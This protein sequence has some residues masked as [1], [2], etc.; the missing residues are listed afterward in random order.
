MKYVK[1]LIA[2]MVAASIIAAAGTT[3]FAEQTDP[4]VILDTREAD[5]GFEDRTFTAVF[6][7][8]LLTDRHVSYMFGGSDGMFRP[9]SELSRAEAAQLI[10]NLLS[11]TE[12]AG[13]DF[14][15]VSRDSWYYKAVSTLSGLGII[16][17][18]ED[19]FLP[20]KAATRAEFVAILSRFFPPSPGTASFTDL[21]AAH[22]A[23]EDIGFAVSKGWVSG[24]SDGS[25]KPDNPITRAEAAC[26]VN[27]ALNRAADKSLLN[28]S[29]LLVFIDVSKGYWAYYDIMEAA[30][31][32]K[33][34][35][36]GNVESWTS[37]NTQNLSL[38]A[39]PLY[40]NG[41]LYYIDEH[42][43][44][45]IK[46][47]TLRGFTFDSL[48][49]YTSGNSELD[50]YVKGVL[51]QVTNDSMSQLEKL[52]AAYDF[53]RDSFTYLRRDN[54]EFGH[55]DWEMKNALIM[56]QTG[57]G[58]CYC[59]TAVFYYLARQ[60]GYECTAVSGLIIGSGGMSPHSWVH[61]DFGGETFIFDPELEMAQRAKGKYDYD[62]FMMSYSRVP[63]RYIAPQ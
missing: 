56:I 39:G 49:Q 60:L 19:C 11:G 2:G 9:N 61:I 16:N 25:F 41:N 12:A 32:H 45:P 58:N 52:R 40:F 15:D 43:H 33:Y 13:R 23:Y 1:R 42:T 34:T 18:Y 30:V 44:Q 26:I 55:T 54:Y 4:A 38:P 24:Y 59:Y 21:S 7:P 63:W 51:S 37:Y 50:G 28:S 6:S 47:T 20:D 29:D 48:G 31:E 22:W 46:N 53:T 17:G 57:L 62:F 35:T 10:Y 14:A 3:A 27:R 5:G 36:S 8:T